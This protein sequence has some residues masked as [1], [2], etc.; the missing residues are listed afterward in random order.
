MQ[1]P[2]R[3]EGKCSG[4]LAW[5]GLQR[6]TENPPRL[7]NHR[8]HFVHCS[9]PL[10]S[11]TGFLL[12]EVH[13]WRF[14]SL[15]LR[16]SRPHSLHLTCLGGSCRFVAVSIKFS[17]SVWHLFFHPDRDVEASSLCVICLCVCV[18][19]GVLCVLHLSICVSVFVFSIVCVCVFSMVLCVCVQHGVSLCVCIVCLCVCLCPIMCTQHWP[20][21]G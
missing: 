18:Q 9:A 17:I 4:S 12:S 21:D 5:S 16:K 3:G 6:C 2:V 8:L 19:H 13:L 11:H 15:S 1:P 14:L 7:L 20:K 10:C